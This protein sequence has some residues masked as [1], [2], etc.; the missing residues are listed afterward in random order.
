MI[1]SS[2]NRFRFMSVLLERT[3]PYNE[4]VSGEHVTNRRN[5]KQQRPLVPHAARNRYGRPEQDEAAESDGIERP[6]GT[7]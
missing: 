6:P 7:R 1:C 4:R 3:Q 2:L 5:R